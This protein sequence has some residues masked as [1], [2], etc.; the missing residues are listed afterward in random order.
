MFWDWCRA[1]TWHDSGLDYKPAYSPG[2][3]ITAGMFNNAI[4]ML[5]YDSSPGVPLIFV[6]PLTFLSIDMI[7]LIIRRLIVCS[8]LFWIWKED[9]VW[10]CWPNSR[11][12]T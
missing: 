10:A 9:E 1:G 3:S 11:E 8:F 6:F 7:K 5:G 4:N 2:G 12:E